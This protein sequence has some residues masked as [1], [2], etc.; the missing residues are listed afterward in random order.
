MVVKQT[1]RYGRDINLK[2]ERKRTKERRDTTTRNMPTNKPKPRN[3]WKI[4]G[5]PGKHN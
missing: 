4:N 3:E 1:T 5:L 2:P